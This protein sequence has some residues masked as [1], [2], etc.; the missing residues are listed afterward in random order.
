MC[1]QI[2]IKHSIPQALQSLVLLPGTPHPSQ[3]T[4]GTSHIIN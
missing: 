3:D 2:Q 1:N 4:Q